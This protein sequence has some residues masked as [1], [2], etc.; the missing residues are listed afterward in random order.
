MTCTRYREQGIDSKD[1]DREIHS[2][3]N[4]EVCLYPSSRAKVGS[5]DRSSPS[6]NFG[7][8]FFPLR[9]FGGV[10]RWEQ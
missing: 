4:E 9:P 6:R 2:E 3:S 8:G 5:L 1:E 7:F 10:V